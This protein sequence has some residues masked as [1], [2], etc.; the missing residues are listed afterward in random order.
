LGGRTVDDSTGRRR[1]S[2]K[3]KNR[4]KKIVM[5]KLIILGGKKETQ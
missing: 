1:E 3:G 4:D 5:V 2:E